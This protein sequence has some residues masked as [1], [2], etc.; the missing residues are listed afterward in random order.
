VQF[1]AIVNVHDG[2][3]QD[4]LPNAEYM[5]AIQALNSFDNIRTIGYVSTTWSARDLNSVLSDV[6]AYSY[7]GENYDSLAMNGIFVDETPTRY[8]LANA[9]YLQTIMQA[10]HASPGLH[11]NFI[12][13]TSLPSQHHS[14][15]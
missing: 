11:D 9:T 15:I 8:S 13:M 1:T 5:S 12:G 4:P 7:W 6:A 14:W 2:P 3:S 10:V